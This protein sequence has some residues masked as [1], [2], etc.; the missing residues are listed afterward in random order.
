[1]EGELIRVAKKGEEGRNHLRNQ[2][3]DLRE[4]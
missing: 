3:I 1:M 2:E 4:G